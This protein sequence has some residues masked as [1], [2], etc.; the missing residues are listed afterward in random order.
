MHEVHRRQWSREEIQA[1]F[2]YLPIFGIQFQMYT[3]VV[4]R[5]ASQIKSFYYNNL[6]RIRASEQ[7][8]AEAQENRLI[9]G[10]LVELMR[11][12]VVDIQEQ[13]RW[14]YE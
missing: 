7:R 14:F 1:V 12:A 5:P 9:S 8:D 3:K 11:L 10:S 6:Q 2:Q 13:G 4:D